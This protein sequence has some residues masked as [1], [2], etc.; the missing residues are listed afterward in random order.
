[1][2]TSV[3]FKNFLKEIHERNLQKLAIEMFKMNNGMSIQL[4]SENFYFSK[5][6][7]NFRHQSETKFEVDHVN[8]EKYSKQSASHFGHKTWNSIP[9][10]IKKR[11]NFG[12][13]ESIYSVSV[14]A[15]SSF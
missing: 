6:H 8:T 10:K 1:M 3:L 2:I 13:L 12:I 7:Y 5:S 14:Q 15:L 11:Y 9:Q 4:V